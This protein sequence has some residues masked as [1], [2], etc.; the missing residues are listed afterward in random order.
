[1]ERGGPRT[2]AHVLAPQ[3][4]RW[5]RGG[6]TCARTPSLD[7]LPDL[8]QITVRLNSSVCKIEVMVVVMAMVII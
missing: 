3:F 6:L 7:Q 8:A 5:G 2:Q 1:M 4:L